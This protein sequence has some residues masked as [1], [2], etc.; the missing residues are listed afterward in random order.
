MI[1][2]VIYG[3]GIES[4][5]LSVPFSAFRKVF[6]EAGSSSLVDVKIDGGASVKA[7][8]KDVQ[9]HP[10]SMEPVHIDFHQVK[11]DEKMTAEIPL[12]VT[13]ES[14]A[15]KVLGGTLMTPVESVE[16]ECL[17]TDL[18]HEI[19]VDISLLKTFDDTITVADLKVGPGVKVLDDPENLVAAVEAPLSEEELAKMEESQVGDVEAV[20]AEGEEKKEGEEGEG[21]EEGSSEG[22]AEEKKNEGDKS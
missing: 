3:S 18:P 4:R 14:E 17:P 15:V 10:L 12:A 7:V 13:G 8:I 1:P 11:M 2:A 6:H 22:T 16:V 9:F 5:S 20:K 21:K 19:V